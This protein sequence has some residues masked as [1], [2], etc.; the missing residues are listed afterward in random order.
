MKSWR[1]AILLVLLLAGGVVVNAWGYL[2]GA[3][4]VERKLGKDFP[5]E[6][7]AW[8][9]TGGDGLI[10]QRD[11]GC[12]TRERLSMRNYRGKDGRTP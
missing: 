11:A 1:F 7:G 12:V 10:K 9:Q 5:K 6:I 4:G 8:Q 3:P 2:G